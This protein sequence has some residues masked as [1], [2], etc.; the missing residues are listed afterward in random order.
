[1]ELVAHRAKLSL[2]AGEL[3][4]SEMALPVERR[5][6]VIRKQF[7]GVLLVDRFGELACLG[8]VGLRRLEP[9]HVGIW[10]I[11]AR[12]R[13][14]GPDAVFDDKEAF[15]RTLAGTPAAVVLV[16]VAGQEASAVRIRAGDEQGCH[17]ARVRRAPR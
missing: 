9:Q 17:A 2:E 11:G 7:A 13:D 16:D 3:R 4:L 6:T 15:G 5:R 14:R 12:P 8:E 10:R 1:L